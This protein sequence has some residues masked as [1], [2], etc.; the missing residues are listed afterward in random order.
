VSTLTTLRRAISGALATIV[1]GSVMGTHAGEP[2]ADG[3]LFPAPSRDRSGYI[4]RSGRMVISP[5]WD[6]AAPFADGLAAV[7]TRQV[8]TDGGVSRTVSRQG[9]IDR[10]GHVV[11]PLRWDDAGAFSEGRARVKEGDRFGFVDRTGAVV[12]PPQYDDAAPFADGLAAVKRDGKTGFIDPAGTVVIPF[13]YMR[14]AWIASFHDGRACAFDGD[15]E[16]DRA[17]FIDRTGA[18]VIP[19]Q[20]A[21]AQPFSEGLALVRTTLDAPIRVIDR[22]GRTVIETG[23][24]DALSFNEGLAAVETA[25]GWTYIDRSGK[26]VIGPL[27]YRHVGVFVDG[28]AGVC[29]GSAWGF[30]DRT[31]REVIPTTWTGIARFQDGLARMESGSLFGGLRVAY[32]DRDGTV[33][34]RAR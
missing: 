15:W 3:P 16:N 22:D 29:R 28:R 12:V 2:P 17:G 27:R 14:A 33:V 26:T 20:Y 34:W 7:G 6:D 25:A 10:S 31:G 1:L 5:Q 21:W 24:T 9:W 13:R 30:I 32:I 23:G 18:M 11:I 8:E 4:D 19:A